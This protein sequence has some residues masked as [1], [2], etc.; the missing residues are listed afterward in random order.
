MP[1]SMKSGLT[2]ARIRLDYYHSLLFDSFESEIEAKRAISGKINQNYLK[3][4][5]IKT[6]Y[7]N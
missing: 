1:I 6:F 4:S 5:R 7:R 3:F 2:A